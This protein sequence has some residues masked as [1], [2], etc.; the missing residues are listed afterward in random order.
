MYNVCLLV[1]P[2][3]LSV[4]PY[5]HLFIFVVFFF[6]LTLCQYLR[7]LIV[8]VRIMADDALCHL[9]GKM[10]NVIFYIFLFSLLYRNPKTKVFRVPLHL[11]KALINVFVFFHAKRFHLFFCWCKNPS[12]MVRFLR[13]LEKKNSFHWFSVPGLYLRLRYQRPSA[14]PHDQARR[15][16]DLQ[17]LWQNAKRCLHHKSPQD[18]WPSQLQQPV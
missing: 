8:A 2:L 12:H 9:F 13:C 3:C 15:Q 5:W 7:A 14:L 10:W 18:A 11:W 1:S 17:H 4:E 16:S 6:L